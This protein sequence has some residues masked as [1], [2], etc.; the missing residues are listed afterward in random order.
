M[1]NSNRR[2]RIEGAID[3]AVTII[4]IAVI[5]TALGVAAYTIH[6]LM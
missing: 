2:Q 3:A 6:T 5:V 4:V 1:K